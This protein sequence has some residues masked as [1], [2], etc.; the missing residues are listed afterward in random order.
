MPDCD[1]CGESF[2]DEDAL[3]SH[4]GAAHYD[5]LGRIDKRRVD[6]YR[7]D[8]AGR[9]LAPFALG[10]VVLIAA[11]LVAYV[12]FFSGGGSSY[13]VNGYEVAQTPT[14]APGQGTHEHGPIVM[15]VKGEQVDFSRPRYQ[16]QAIPF[17]FEGGDGS[18]W[19][20]HA[21]GV[22]LEYAMAT[23]GIGVSDD[24]VTVKGTTYTDGE[25]AQVTVSVNGN[26]INPAT[27]VLRDGD[28][29]RIVVKSQ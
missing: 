25:N 12:L 11:A 5:D 20:T 18:T 29:V 13:E 14:G 28:S 9:D 6:Q 7:G 15:V 27:Y 1:H 26:D 21:P 22:T 23:L 8:D 24:S 10:G 17:H 16:R 3:L 4:L 2:A 19:H